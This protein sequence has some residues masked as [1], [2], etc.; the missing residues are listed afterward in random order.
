MIAVGIDVSEARGCA[1]VALSEEYR[2]VAS[3]W[4]GDA[5]LPPSAAEL[6]STLGALGPPSDVVVAI[7]APRMAMPN[8][9]TWEW[10]RERWR[11]CTPR[12]GRHCEVVVRNTGIA[13]PQ[14]TPSTNGVAPVWMQIGFDLFR[15][16]AARY[17]TL[18]VF[19]SA[20]YRMLDVDS[21]TVPINFAGFARAPKDMLDAYVAAITALEFLA[22]RGCEVGGGDG[23]GTIVLPRPL[24]P[25]PAGILLWPGE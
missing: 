24:P 13:N 20:S 6:L 1:W 17:R 9:R 15:D 21:M 22:G 23:L 7:D 3:G 10:S 2:Q 8:L 25:A 12:R 4:I 16:L 19:P 11:R 18:E 14:W 5:A